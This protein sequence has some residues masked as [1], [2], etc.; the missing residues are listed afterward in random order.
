MK[1][2]KKKKKKT[3]KQLWKSFQKSFLGEDSSKNEFTIVEVIIIIL[4]SILFGVIIGYL[5]SFH[6]TGSSSIQ[7]NPDE[8]IDTYYNIVD[9]Y[10]G[11]I[12]PDDLKNAAIKGMVQSLKDP[13]S[14]YMDSNSTTS[15]TDTVDG[16]FVGIGVTIIYE[17]PYTKIIEVYENSPAEKAGLLP[18]DVII[19][20]GKEDVSGY[21]GSQ[22]SKLIRGKKGTKVKIT[23]LR[24]EKEKEFEVTRGVVELKSVTSKTFGENQEI[25]YIQ[26]TSFATNT[27]DQFQKAFEE[28]E[29]Q[30]ITSLILDV[31]GNPGGHLQQTRQILSNFFSKK[32]VLYQI[33]TKEK[34]KKIYSENNEKRSYPIIVLI[35]SSS[36]SAAEVF[37][38]CFQDN[39]KQ[40]TIMGQ[41]SYGK[42]TV[43]KS[44]SLSS[45]SSIKYTTQKWLTSKG[46]WL[47]EKG[48]EPDE[49]VEQA[50]EYYE[51]PVDELD[52]I[53]NAAI[54]K[55]KESNLEW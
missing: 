52:A 51:N 31:R 25:G 3:F 30:N 16:S 28:L 39:Y 34:K 53:L 55:L 43:Q 10:Y 35:D 45:G 20:V 13:Y 8:I 42:G 54:N 22:L 1:K 50:E 27:A 37:A 7:D 49:V 19:K 36:A 48:V 23:V 4:I 5:L 15:F 29:K 26:I 46:E 44:Q 32:T 18:D 2:K 33:E 9:N 12:N 38:S 40:A 47:N 24:E 41:K 14:I 17:E 21:Q 11:E 6:R